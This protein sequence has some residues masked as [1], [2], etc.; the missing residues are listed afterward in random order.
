MEQARG[1]SQLPTFSIIYGLENTG[2]T[3]NPHSSNCVMQLQKKN[4]KARGQPRLSCKRLLLHNYAFRGLIMA[5]CGIK[6]KHKSPISYFSV[7]NF[8]WFIW[9]TAG[10]FTAR[11][12]KKRHDEPACGHTRFTN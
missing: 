3:K 12:R 1:T 11:E 6:G 4:S 7:K 10:F 9:I 2:E 8:S 5:G